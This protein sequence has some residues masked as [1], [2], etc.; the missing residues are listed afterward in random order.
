MTDSLNIRR[1]KI[2]DWPRVWPIVEPVFNAGETYALP[3]G[4][5][6]AEGFEV[7]IT[8]PLKTYVAEDAN[9]KI[10]GT[11]FI[12]ANQQGRGSHV[13]NAGYITGAAARGKGV[14]SAMCEHSQEEAV[15]NGF[16][17]MQ[18]NLVVA[19]NEEAVR[20]WE[21]LGFEIVGT[22]PKAFD[23]PKE[24]FVDAHV[25]YKWLSDIDQ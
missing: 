7:W 22:L 23:H 21:K 14:A 13:C 12:K 10:L 2:D 11:Y 5:S 1:F 3:S 16:K 15:K 8:R 19:T 9:G 24:G 6:S 20:L 17:A 4:M 18:F 25:M